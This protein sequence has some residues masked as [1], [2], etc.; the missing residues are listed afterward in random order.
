MYVVSKR[1]LYHDCH[2]VDVKIIRQVKN[3]DGIKRSEEESTIQI[4]E[5][6]TLQEKMTLPF[7]PPFPY[8]V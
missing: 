1:T 4:K 7:P 3:S 8:F 5:K 6:I 2:C